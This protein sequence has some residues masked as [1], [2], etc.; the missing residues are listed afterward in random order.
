ML[1]FYI[2]IQQS[3]RLKSLS[4]TPIN[5][6]Y[7]CLYIFKMSS[8]LITFSSHR[9]FAHIL[10]LHLCHGYFKKI[11]FHREKVAKI[12]V[13]TWPCFNLISSYSNNSTRWLFFSLGINK[14]S[15]ITNSN[16]LP[17]SL[18]N[19]I[20]FSFFHANCVNMSDA[21]TR[22]IKSAIRLAYF[23]GKEI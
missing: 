10:R 11:S 23:D 9:F 5:M 18:W 3:I 16:A 6:Q 12:W 2:D 17:T 20:N 4:V 8:S 22:K 19:F 21:T 7:I 1:K 13:S 14:S 15:R